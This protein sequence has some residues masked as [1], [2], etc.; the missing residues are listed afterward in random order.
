MNDKLVNKEHPLYEYYN[1][2]TINANK[3]EE[4]FRTKLRFKW[5]PKWRIS[6]RYIKE[7][8]TPA[9]TFDLNVTTYE[10]I[11]DKRIRERI[12]Y[13]HDDLVKGRIRYDIEIIK[14][15]TLNYLKYASIKQVEGIEAKPTPQ[16]VRKW[17]RD[18]KLDKSLLKLS[19][20]EQD[21]FY[22]NLEK[23]YRNV[24]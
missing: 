10:F 23:S 3:K 22:S 20:E 9:G 18:F 8:F 13:F 6:K 19:K 15:Y 7:W 24:E 4:E 5:Q 14:V 12:T 11:N 17:I 2:R 21:K 1:N 16:A